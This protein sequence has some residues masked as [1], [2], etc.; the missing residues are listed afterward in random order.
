[1]SRMGAEL[2]ALKSRFVM[3]E[4]ESQYQEES[5]RRAVAEGGNLRGQLAQFQDQVD[6]LS[7]QL[8]FKTQEVSKLQSALENARS[9]A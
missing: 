3:V 6:E 8:Y 1:M 9:Q 4:Q 5:Y 2:T 7:N